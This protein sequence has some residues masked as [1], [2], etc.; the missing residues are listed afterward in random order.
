MPGALPKSILPSDVLFDIANGLT[1]A[2]NMLMEYELVSGGYT[3][4]TTNV[5]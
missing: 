5:H 2:Y 4:K 3:A 1:D